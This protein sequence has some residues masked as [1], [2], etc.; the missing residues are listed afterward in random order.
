[1]GLWKGRNLASADAD[2]Y[3]ETYQQ[4]H[5]IFNIERV[6]I[7]AICVYQRLHTSRSLE[8]R[9]FCTLIDNEY[10]DDNTDS[11]DIR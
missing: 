11:R 9:F 1:M 3:G 7:I 6:L 4:G 5:M 2:Y 10:D 8:K